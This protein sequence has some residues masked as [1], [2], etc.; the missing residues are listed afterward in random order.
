[1]AISWAKFLATHTL[2]PMVGHPGLSGNAPA[3]SQ[4]S[5]LVDSYPPPRLPDR[6]QTLW[7]PH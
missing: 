3:H 5:R 6:P 1:M 7:G 2:D 4:S